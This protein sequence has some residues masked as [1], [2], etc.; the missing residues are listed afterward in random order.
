MSTLNALMGVQ[1]L[2]ILMYAV[3]DLILSTPPS[4][5]FMSKS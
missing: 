3:R 5:E 2:M 1:V 4:P